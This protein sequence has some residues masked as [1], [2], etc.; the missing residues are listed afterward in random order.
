MRKLSKVENISI[1]KS[2]RKVIKRKNPN[3][4]IRKAKRNRLTIIEWF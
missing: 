2:N 4:R 1:L 3:R